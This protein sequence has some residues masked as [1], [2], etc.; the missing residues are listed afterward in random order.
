[1]LNPTGLGVDLAVFFLIDR[2]DVSKYVKNHEARAGSA[3]I[4]SG[5]IFW[6]AASINPWDKFD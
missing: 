1:M 5:C 4:D 3:L 2:D 6:H